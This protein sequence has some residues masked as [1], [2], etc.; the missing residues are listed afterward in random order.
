M[1]R[2][3]IILLL[4]TAV[5][6][7]LTTFAIGEEA[8]RSQWQQEKCRIY[9]EA[10]EKALDF[11]GS[12]DMNYNF[13]AGNE[14][15]IAGGCTEQANVCPRSAQ[16]LEIANALTIALMNAGAASTFLPFRCAAQD[17]L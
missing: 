3:S 17:Q 15:F 4:I 9:G 5:L 12:D 8:E 7:F 1:K 11:F 2:A 6:P 13:M 16:E 14:N 10:W